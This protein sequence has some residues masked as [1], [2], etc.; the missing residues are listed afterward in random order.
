MEDMDNRILRAYHQAAC[1]RYHAQADKT[2]SSPMGECSIS[3]KQITASDYLQLQDRKG[4]I[5]LTTANG[6]IE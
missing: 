6:K 1:K 5:S 4:H 2:I 3:V